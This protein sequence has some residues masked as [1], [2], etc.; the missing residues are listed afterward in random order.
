MDKGNELS[1]S[2]LSW[3]LGAKLDR[4]LQCVAPDI[5]PMESVKPL[6]KQPPILLTLPYNTMLATTCCPAAL[7]KRELQTPPAAELWGR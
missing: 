3:L 5:S 4:Q 2:G 7:L 6:L 1:T